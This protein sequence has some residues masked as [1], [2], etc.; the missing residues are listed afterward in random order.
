ML[1]N[2]RAEGNFYVVVVQNVFLI[3]VEPSFKD[4]ARSLLPIIVEP[5]FKDYCRTKFLFFDF[6]NES[7]KKKPR[8]SETEYECTHLEHPRMNTSA[9]PPPLEYECTQTPRQEIV[10]SCLLPVLLR[11]Y[12]SICTTAMGYEST[13]TRLGFYCAIHYDTDYYIHSM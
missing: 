2:I 6:K 12:E 7:T 8:Y 4:H 3:V 5:S 1:L 10:G 13:C 9:T 11:W